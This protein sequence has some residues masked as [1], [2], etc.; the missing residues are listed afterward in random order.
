MN[1]DAKLGILVPLGDLVFLQR[2]PV[3]TEGTLVHDPIHLAEN[4]GARDVIFRTRLLPGLIDHKWIFRRGRGR[5]R[6]W[7]L[8]MQG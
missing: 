5:G 8:G 1:E 7:R 2:L 6:G 4:C 3:G